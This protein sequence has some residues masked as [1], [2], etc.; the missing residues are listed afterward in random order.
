MK[1]GIVVYSQT[2][3]TMSAA[4][5]ILGRLAGKGHSAEIVAVPAEF[6]RS[7]GD[8]GGYDALIFGAPVQAFT[9]A[10]AMKKYLLSIEPL[11]NKRA[12]CFVT[13]N[14]SPRFGGNRAVG[15]MSRICRG[16]GAEIY[17]T[18]IVR[19]DETREETLETL[20]EKLCAIG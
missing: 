16:K 11:N 17:Q 12:A 20:C 19:W 3:N 2:G 6:R 14:L 13:Q 10:R 5:K 7:G 8:L 4:Q 9:L 1:I 15:I 18:G